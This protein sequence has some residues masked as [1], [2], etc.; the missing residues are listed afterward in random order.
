VAVNDISFQ[1]FPGVTGLLGP[2][3][4]GKTTLLHMLAGLNKLSKGDIRVLGEPVRGNT[5]I[6]RRI[7]VMSEHEAVYGFFT[8]REM[9]EFSARMQ[10]V[11]DV[12]ASADW[13]IGTVHLTDS[14]H[15]R[16]G[17]YS[18]GMRQR[19]RLAAAIV[20]DPEVLILDE[21]LNGTDPRQRIEFQV[22]MR[23]LGEEG[24]TILISSH[25]LEEVETLADTTLL[26]VSG[27]LAASGDF[28]AIR[29]KL[30]DRPFSVRVLA[31]AP[32]S[33]AAAL[34][35]LPAIDS[36]AMEPDGSLIVLTKDVAVLQRTIA[37]LA[38]EA[39]IRLYRVEPL[40]ES[41]ESVFSYVAQR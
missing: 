13:A 33:I 7:G 9:V 8:G 34:V 11:K 29:Q 32:R 36:V 16:M 5:R 35:R 31:E 14:Q 24:R 23:K 39:K 38:Q 2:N 19:M 3:G 15:R 41:L 25:I 18:R 6:Y 12:K 26:L 20:H 17:T 30:D 22:L 1:V 37:K 10:G 28:R 40:D 27:K 4:A 21:P